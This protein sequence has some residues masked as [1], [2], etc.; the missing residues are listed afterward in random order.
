MA[1]IYFSSDLQMFVVFFDFFDKIQVSVVAIICMALSSWNV[2]G[3]GDPAERRTV[4]NF[5][6]F[7]PDVVLL[8]FKRPNWITPN[9]YR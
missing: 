3:L 7:Q 9:Q 6:W 4:R 2:R 5:F 8:F 1:S